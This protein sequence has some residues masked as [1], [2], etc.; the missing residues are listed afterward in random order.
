MSL[1]RPTTQR[2]IACSDIHA[3]LEALVVTLRDCAKVIRKKNFQSHRTDDDLYQQLELPN[4]NDPSYIPDLGYEWSGDDT[5]FVI[6]GDLIDGARESDSVTKSKGIELAYY[7][8][9]EIKLLRFINAINTQARHLNGGIVKVLGNH[10][11]ENFKGNEDM[12]DDYAFTPDRDNECY[13]QHTDGTWES[14]KTFFRFGH[15]GYRLYQETLGMYIIFRVNNLL[16]VHGQLPTK[17]FLDREAT[18]LTFETIHG[19]LR[20]PYTHEVGEK[21][22]LYDDLIS[23]VLWGREYGDPDERPNEK[24]EDMEKRIKSDITAFCGKV[25]DDNMTIFVGHCQQHL[26]HQD[27]SVRSTLG[28]FCRRNKVTETFDNTE[29]YTG[30]PDSKEQHVN[31][32]FGIV[33]EWEYEPKQNRHI[34]ILVKLD[35]G[36][37]RGQ[38]YLDDYKNLQSGD[39]LERDFFRPRAPT[40]CEVIG[41][42]MQIIRSTMS[43]MALHI[44]R[45]AYMAYKPS[46]SIY[47]APASRKTK[48]KQKS[49]TE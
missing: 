37:G 42:K 33:T 32:T 27:N 19:L 47:D 49:K 2:V 7:P 20:Q 8:Q 38:E 36:V 17:K 14:R 18:L 39:V 30:K 1:Q 24:E 12:V 34:P 11:Y 5:I 40:V 41:S 22:K 4:V 6:V 45:D 29:I 16:F 48:K 26:V 35:V 25:C 10:D 28:H 44:K 31:K 15:E 9:V 23:D 46:P 43:N 13:Y 3:D 21:I